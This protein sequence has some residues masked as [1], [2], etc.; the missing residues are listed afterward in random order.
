MQKIC[1]QLA[2]IIED[3]MQTTAIGETNYE[4]DLATLG[5]TSIGFIQVIVQIEEEFQITIPD[6]FLLL[7]KLNTVNKI[8][9]IV[10][11]LLA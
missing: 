10:L 8:A 3:I 2:K 9:S 1:A 7:S 5:L 6:E 4:D 11:S